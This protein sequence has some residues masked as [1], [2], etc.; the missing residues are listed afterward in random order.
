MTSRDGKGVPERGRRKTSSPTLGP[1]ASESGR[2]GSCDPVRPGPE[3]TVPGPRGRPG[4]SRPVP[5]AHPSRPRAWLAADCRLAAAWCGSGRGR[6]GRAPA[7]AVSLRWAGRLPTFEIDPTTVANDAAIPS[8]AGA[9]V[10][11]AGTANRVPTGIARPADGGSAAVVRS[12]TATSAPTAETDS[13]GDPLPP[14]RIRRLGQLPRPSR[15]RARSIRYPP[16]ERKPIPVTRVLWRRPTQVRRSLA[17]AISLDSDPL[18][19][20]E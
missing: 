18:R 12:G 6:P 16:D 13:A 19:R 15:R 2:T 7:D 8:F 5:I 20:I 10:I 17:D 4:R 3:P 11:A 9:G 14:E 1:E